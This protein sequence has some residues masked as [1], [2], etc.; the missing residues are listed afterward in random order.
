MST[1]EIEQREGQILLSAW[2][3]ENNA[4]KHK[5]KKNSCNFVKNACPC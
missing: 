2:M 1:E 5:G 3:I 4:S